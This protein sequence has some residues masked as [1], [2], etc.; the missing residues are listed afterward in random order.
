[1]SIFILFG[2]M[3][4]TLIATSYDK[5]VVI[6]HPLHY[7]VIMNLC[8]CCFL[9]LVSLLV[10][11]FESQVHSRIVLKFTCFK[12]VEISNFFCDL[13]QLL[14]LACSDIFT[15]NIV[16]YIV[17]VISGFPLYQRSFSLT[18]KLFLSCRESPQ[19]VGNISHSLTW[20]VFAYFMEQ[21]L[22]CTSAQPP[23]NLSAS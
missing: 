13:S 18:I 5:F 14:H 9:V 3:D 2:C 8:L 7:L 4:G 11:L 20:Q 10:S 15:S 1:M 6:C 16:M 22:V 19:Q 17:G 12:N 21:A 23:H